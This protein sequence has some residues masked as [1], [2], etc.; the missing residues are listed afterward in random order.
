[1]SSSEGT[2]LIGA[3][4][5]VEIEIEILLAG[6]R[7]PHVPPETATQPLLARLNGRLVQSCRPGGVAIIETFANR[8]VTGTLHGEVGAP[9]VSFGAPN[10]PLLASAGA[11]VVRRRE[12]RNDQPA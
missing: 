2:D 10:A 8:T 7:A 12:Q 9:P 11:A 4:T 3:G 6:K 5:W 1:M